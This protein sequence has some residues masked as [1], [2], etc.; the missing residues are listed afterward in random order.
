MNVRGAA[1]VTGG[2]SGIGLAT[3]YELARAGHRV[4]LLG[5]HDD[6]TG[7]EVARDLGTGH[8]YVHCDVS[9][10]AQV[11]DA[12]REVAGEI[13]LVEVLV[14]NAGVGSLNTV[15]ELTDAD[16]ENVFGVD[17]KAMWLCTKHALPQMRRLGA[18]AIVN[19]SSIHAHLTRPGTFPYAAAKSGVLGLTRSLALELADDRVRVN[20]VCPG[21]V[22]TPPMMEQYDTRPDPA[23]AW[24]RLNSVHPMGRIGEPHEI[25]AVVAFLASS[26]ASFVTGASWNVD[27]GLSARFAT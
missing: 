7:R 21:Y 9:N 15:E 5:A 19:I 8:H 6:N 3:A 27:G 23:T 18:G 10:E 1:V 12:M 17:L 11:V 25:A 14:N 26:R 22:R 13:G 16:W 4:A 20:A 2:T 24:A